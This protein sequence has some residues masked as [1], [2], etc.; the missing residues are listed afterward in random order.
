MIQTD[1]KNR[2]YVYHHVNKT[3][4]DIFYVGKG[5]G[6][7]AY[8]TDG[9][10]QYWI[11]YVNKYKEYDVVIVYNNLTEE[12]AFEL[13]TKEINRIGRS[14][15]KEGTL[16]NILPGGRSFPEEYL[17]FRKQ[18]KIKY[19]K[20]DNDSKI[21]LMILVDNFIK[22]I[23]PDPFEKF[24]EK[25]QKENDILTKPIYNWCDLNEEE[26]YQILFEEHNIF[27]HNISK[28]KQFKHLKKAKSIDELEKEYLEKMYNLKEKRYGK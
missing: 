25:Y 9:R 21:Q 7:R 23:P 28:R 18:K 3:N 2:Y 8:K 15:Y 27:I 16:V 26:R 12:E 13:E 1:T 20:N 14:I 11:N 10:N 17:N 5:A 19:K 4:G 24:I 22:R 6:D